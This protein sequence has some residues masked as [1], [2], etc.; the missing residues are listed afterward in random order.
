ME[1]SPGL[2]GVVMN[3]T[4]AI[5]GFVEPVLWQRQTLNKPLQAVWIRAKKGA[6]CGLEDVE[7]NLILVVMRSG[8]ASQRKQSL[9]GT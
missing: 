4:D 2:V 7:R 5:L 3:E 1:H 6:C 9:S 8:K